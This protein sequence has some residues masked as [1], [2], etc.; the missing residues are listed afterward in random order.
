MKI[1][2]LLDNPL[3]SLLFTVSVSIFIY[4]LYKKIYKQY[5]SEIKSNKSLYTNTLNTLNTVNNIKRVIII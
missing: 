1:V 2:K 3:I 5:N 4:I